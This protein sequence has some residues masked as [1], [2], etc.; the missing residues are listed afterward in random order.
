MN[1]VSMKD[2][3]Q[4]MTVEP[5]SYGLRIHLNDDQCEALGIKT[6]PAAGTR[7]MIQAA[8]FICEATQRVEQDGDDT[9]ADICLE[10]QITDMGVEINDGKTPAQ[11]MYDKSNMAA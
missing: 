11:R 2:D 4:A 1:L 10:L 7:V 6:M 8:A 3:A 9:G 5:Y